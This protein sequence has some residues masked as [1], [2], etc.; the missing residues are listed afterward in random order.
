MNLATRSIAKRLAAMFALAALLVFTLVGLALSFVLDRELERQQRDEL[1]T[2]MAFTAQLVGRCPSLEKWPNLTDKLE[3]LTPADGSTQ[4]AITSDDPRFTYGS[5]MAA[6]MRT[7]SMTI[8]SKG[9]RPAV[10]V[11]VGV[12]SAQFQDTLSSFQLA[13]VVLSALG[14]ALVALLGHRIARLGLGPLDRLSQEARALSPKNLTQRLKLEP[15]PSELSD[16]AASFNG[17]LDRLEG[18]YV[19]LEGFNADVA[20]ELR[21]PIANMVG[22]TQ[23][24][25]SKERSAAELEEVL[26]SNLEELERVRMIVN[27][28]LFLA[29][30]DQG[31]TANHRQRASLRQEIEKTLEFLEPII[32]E[33]QVSVRIAGD[34]DAAIEVSLFHR[35][36]T[37]LIQNAVQ[38]TSPGEEIVVEVSGQTPLLK[39]VVANP[40]APIPEQVLPRLFDRFFRV[41]ASRAS[42]RANHGLGL[43][44]VKAIALMHGGGVFASSGSG[45]TQVGFTVAA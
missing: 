25:L 23:V 6:S 36:I 41:E 2:T 31:E 10:H 11:T 24:V 8:A 35:A 22:Q 18:A 26:Q 4:F 19:Q 3:A 27:D 40:G 20:H 14:V 45:R 38:H 34:A 33:A 5:T 1:A 32:D 28:M 21:T 43:S 13:L 29:R 44:I 17:A 7:T 15:L 12:D 37:N 42:D 39:V 30:A 9:E 16:L